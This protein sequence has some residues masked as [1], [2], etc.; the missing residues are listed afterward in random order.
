ML[1]LRG[2]SG[3]ICEEVSDKI[4]VVSCEARTKNFKNHL[5]YRKSRN[6]MHIVSYS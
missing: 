1:K 4:V 3:V 6:I 2:W 5:T